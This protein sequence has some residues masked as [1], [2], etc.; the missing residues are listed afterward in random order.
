MNSTTSTDVEPAAQQ[1][2]HSCYNHWH[3]KPC[4]SCG[5]PRACCCCRCSCNRGCCAVAAAGALAAKAAK[6][7]ARDNLPLLSLQSRPPECQPQF[8]SKTGTPSCAW[9]MGLAHCPCWHSCKCRTPM[10]QSYWKAPS[11]NGLAACFVGSIW[12]ET[13]FVICDRCELCIRC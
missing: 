9:C 11:K 7:S 1:W 8:H 12:Q 10:Q 2:C 6:N 13:L 4:N 5:L 3:Q